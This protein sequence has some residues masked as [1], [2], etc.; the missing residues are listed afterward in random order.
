MRKLSDAA[1]GV[2]FEGSASSASNNGSFNLQAPAGPSA[3]Y[4]YTSRGSVETSATIVNAAYAAPVTNVLAGF[5]D[6][7]GDSALLRIN[8]TQ[9]AS[10]AA[11]QGTGNYLTYSHFIGRREGTALPFNGRVYQLIVRYGPN[12]STSQVTETEAFVN[13]KTGAY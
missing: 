2:V 5:G 13:S 3:S 6:I 7:S 12:L 8:G 11:D 10:S 1:V 9:V 4:S